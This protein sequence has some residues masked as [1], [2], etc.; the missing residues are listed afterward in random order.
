MSENKCP[1][2]GS[3]ADI[4]PVDNIN[5]KFVECP[6][7]GRLEMN[8]T[9]LPFDGKPIDND[10]LASYLFYNNGQS[11]I[12]IDADRIRFFNFIGHKE[13]FDRVKI[14]CPYSFYVTNNIVEAWYPSTF[15]E[16][17]DMF[18]LM[19]YNRSHFM[20]DYVIFS[21]EQLLSACFAI[22]ERQGVARKI[23]DVSDQCTQFT[24][25]LINQGYIKEIV[26]GFQLLPDG[27]KRVDEL[28]K[29]NSNNKNVFVSMAF[30]DYTKD[31]REAIRQGI[32][33]AGYSAEFI[34]EI[35][36]NKQ[37]VP[38]MFRL[39][40]ESRFLILDISDPNYGAYYEAGYALGLG[41]EVIICCNEDIFHG[42]IKVNGKAPTEEEKDKF[43][44]YFR[45]HFDIAQKQIL[46]WK[47]YED[48]TKKLEE[49]IK[50]II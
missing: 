50:S 10:K 20:G 41:K 38:E 2:C 13:F 37:I 46:V 18:L 31:T 30:S 21:K 34:D 33:N 29:S 14:K 4:S 16:K 19:M 35:I 48:L 45:P 43:G 44:K 17:V 27:Y 32:I 23:L 28:Q 25:Y 9:G 11:N 47:D 15:N 26:S 22:R 6:C 12:P 36:H 40:R 1:I 8:I 5:Y 7:C 24:N 49:W 3:E 39:I 42:N